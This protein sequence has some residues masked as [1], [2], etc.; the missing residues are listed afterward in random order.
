MPQLPFGGPQPSSAF[1]IADC[2]E[3]VVSEKQT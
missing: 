1:S 3:P 2:D